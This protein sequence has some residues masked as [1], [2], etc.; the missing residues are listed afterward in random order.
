MKKTAFILL[1]SLA[2]GACAELNALTGQTNPF[3]IPEADDSRMVVLNTNT[4]VYHDA[5]CAKAKTCTKN[6]IVTTKYNAKA[7]GAL[8]CQKCS[9]GNS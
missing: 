6:C 2:L 1:F 7:S 5:K 8:P 4:H 3:V 9:G